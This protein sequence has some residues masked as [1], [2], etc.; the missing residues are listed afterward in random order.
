[1]LIQQ[2]GEKPGQRWILAEHSDRLG[3][4]RLVRLSGSE[5]PE[6]K[7]ANRSRGFVV[8]SEQNRRIELERL[9]ASVQIRV[10][11]DRLKSRNPQAVRSDRFSPPMARFGMG[12]GD[13]EQGVDD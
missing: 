7:V 11:D 9:P 13:P 12:G 4:C 6:R 5:R 10:Y 8:T 2:S 3:S 1:M